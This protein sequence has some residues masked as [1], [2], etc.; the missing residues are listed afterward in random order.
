MV[1]RTRTT[2]LFAQTTP[3]TQFGSLAGRTVLARLKT[4]GCLTFVFCVSLVAFV[5]RS[6]ATDDEPKAVTATEKQPTDEESSR[7]RPETLKIQVLRR[8]TNE[9]VADAKIQVQ[10]WGKQTDAR[11]VLTTD[12]DGYATFH[13]PD[14]T[15]S[16]Q[17]WATVH[18]AGLVP[19]FVS[20]G[21]AVAP[22][23]LPTEK[24]IHLDTGKSIGGTV[25]NL[26]GHPVS[27]AKISITVP[28]TDSP[29]QIHYLLLD[30]STDDDGRW[31]FDGAPLN[32]AGIS[33]YI[34][35]PHYIKTGIPVQDRTDGRYELDPGLSMTGRVID[36][37]GQP[38]PNAQITV[39]RDRWGR[40]ESPA[41][42]N[43]DGTY[44]VYALKAEPTVVT[45]E[46][47]KLAPQ[48]QSVVIRK[49]MKPVDFQLVAGKVTRIRVLNADGEPIAGARV[50]AD[51]WKTLRPLWWSS[52]TDVQGEVSWD[53]APDEPVKFHLLASGYASER[54]AVLSPQDEPHTV[55][56]YKPLR[57]DGT[58]T[59][60]KN[61]KIPEFRVELGHKFNNQKEIYWM[62]YESLFGA[63][64]KFEVNYD[65]RCEEL[66]LKI[67]AKGYRSWISKGFTF[68]DSPHKAFVKLEPVEVLYSTVVTP[69]GPPAQGTRLFFSTQSKRLMFRGNFESYNEAA[70]E[71]A[72]ERGK[73]AI[74]AL[75]EPML[76]VAVHDSGYAEITSHELAKSPQIQLQPWSKVEVVMTREGRPVPNAVFEISPQPPIAPIIQVGTY[77]MSGTTDADG[78]IVFSRVV[79]RAST[80]IRILPQSLGNMGM[81]HNAQQR[82]IPLKPDETTRVEFGNAGAVVKGR[83]LMQGT[84]PQ[85]HHWKSNPPLRITTNAPVN[86]AKPTTFLNS[87]AN[88]LT[89]KREVP[90]APRQQF[91]SLIDDDGSFIIDDVPPGT[92]TLNVNLKAI[93]N[94]ANPFDQ[95]SIGIIQKQIEI[96]KDQNV[97]DL[98]I[99]EETWKSKGD[100]TQ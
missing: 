52:L 21:R 85:P 2:N 47:P 62:S 30:V 19:Y 58:V 63:S 78:R 100:S 80:I 97:V 15:S 66:F 72:D 33:V 57:I 5:D 43:A 79:P 22:K 12:A 87:I 32:L 98:G 84:P 34:Q 16:V 38:V 45:A 35:H 18:A 75:D 60:A 88:T 3:M 56:M 65:E 99:I 11:P 67:E 29:Y 83:L 48:T 4:I 69:Q 25:V 92:Y 91:I 70:K 31:S 23:A 59:N 94:D 68:A 90:M 46:A 50:L 20:W 6:I 9:P 44:T 55:V 77:G 61:K 41:I 36:N 86:A 96:P 89:G 82:N 42:T 10:M 93:S 49:Q 8:D 14:G 54:D 28:A 27:G 24:V 95:K 37:E 81:Q 73:F 64:G 40:V 74:P 7:T 13:Y 71:E 1:C 39:G 53:G 51:T 76:V 26:D 17:L